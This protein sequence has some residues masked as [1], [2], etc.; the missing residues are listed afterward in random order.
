MNDFLI[1]VITVTKQKTQII[2]KILI[3]HKQEEVRKLLDTMLCL[4]YI[5]LFPLNEFEMIT[6]EAKLETLGN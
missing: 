3:I 1:H 5:Y 4:H 2:K 6:L